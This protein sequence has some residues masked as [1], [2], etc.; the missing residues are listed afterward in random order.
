MCTALADEISGPDPRVIVPVRGA[1][2]RP[3]ISVRL[4]VVRSTPSTPP[5]GGLAV[6]PEAEIASRL[7]TV[8][9]VQTPTPTWESVGPVPMV[10]AVGRGVSTL[11]HRGSFALSA[12]RQSI[13]SIV[14]TPAS[15]LPPSDIV[16]PASWLAPFDEHAVAP[17]RAAIATRPRTVSTLLLLLIEY[18]CHRARS[19][20]IGQQRNGAGPSSGLARAQ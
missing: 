18:V 7:C 1:A 11:L 19:V 10:P 20:A 5:N 14:A 15:W 6:T 4:P 9:T 13:G 3:E 12:E 8:S 2:H 17:T 16:G